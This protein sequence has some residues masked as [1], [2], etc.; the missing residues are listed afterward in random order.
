MG[1]P[2]Y[3]SRSAYPRLHTYSGTLWGKVWLLSKYCS[4][5]QVQFRR[6]GGRGSERWLNWMCSAFLECAIKYSRS[7][8]SQMM[9]TRM[10]MNRAYHQVP[11]GL[12]PSSDV[13]TDTRL[14]LRGI[15]VHGY[16]SCDDVPI[17]TK[18]S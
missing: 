9:P 5:L 14:S 16:E 8:F 10:G 17:C 2:L 15:V 4:A 7:H 3:S 12:Y 18:T 6:Y 1:I 13:S 11:A